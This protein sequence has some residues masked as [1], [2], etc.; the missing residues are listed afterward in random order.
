MTVQVAPGVTI[1]DE[2]IAF[3]AVRSS[4]PGGQNVNKVA[5]KVELRV[6]VA[7]IQGLTMGA[8]ERLK[9]LAGS[10]WI[11]GDVLLVTASETRNQVENRAIAEAKLVALVQEALVI[12]KPRRKTR[13]TKA[14]QERRVAAKKGRSEIKRGRGTVRG[15]E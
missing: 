5:S 7:A 8:R 2:A 14:S 13:P 11:E 1:P 6:P 3:N 10:R 15:D 12:P 4:G 9:A